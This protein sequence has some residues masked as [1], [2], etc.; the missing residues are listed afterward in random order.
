MSSRD[1]NDYNVRYRIWERQ[2]QQQQQQHQHQHQPQQRQQ[3]SL[4]GLVNP[5]SFSSTPNLNAGAKPIASFIERQQQRHEDQMQL[6]DWLKS[7]PPPSA[8][9]SNNNYFTEANASQQWNGTFEPLPKEQYDRK[10]D[11]VSRK[12]SSS[13]SS[14][15]SPPA[16]SQQHLNQAKQQQ[17]PKQLPRASS[18]SNSSRRNVTNKRHSNKPVKNMLHAFTGE[19][20]SELSVDAGEA[21]RVLGEA[22]ANGWVLVEKIDQSSADGKRTG[23]NGSRSK[24]AYKGYIPITY[25]SS[26]VVESETPAPK[27]SRA[28]KP[29]SQKEPVQRQQQK[30]EVTGGV[31]QQ[32]SIANVDID[33]NAS[34]QSMLRNDS[35]I[36]E[37]QE[38]QR[39]EVKPG[40][41]VDDFVE[42]DVSPLDAAPRPLP[43]VKRRIAR[44]RNQPAVAKETH[45]QQ[46]PER[47]SYPEQQQQQQQQRRAT[48]SV[49]HNNQQ[50]PRGGENEAPTPSWSSPNKANNARERNGMRQ[51]QRPN[52]N[53]KL[54]SASSEVLSSSSPRKDSIKGTSRAE[55]KR[56]SDQRKG[57]RKP[58][59]PPP[60]PPELPSWDWEDKPIAKTNET[61]KSTDGSSWLSQPHPTASAPV[62]GD[63]HGGSDDLVKGDGAGGVSDA[64]PM[65]GSLSVP[66]QYV[67]EYGMNAM[68]RELHHARQMR[69]KPSD[70]S[71]DASSASGED[72]SSWKSLSSSP[73]PPKDATT[74]NGRKSESPR[75]AMDG[76]DRNSKKIVSSISAPPP[77]KISATKPLEARQQ[78]QSARSPSQQQQKKPQG[79]K[80]RPGGRG[81][82]STDRSSNSLNLRPRSADT[83][84]DAVR[85]L[86]LHS[87][88]VPAASEDRKN[89][90]SMASLDWLDP[91]NVFIPSTSVSNAA[92]AAAVASAAAMAP[93]PSVDGRK[94]RR[95][96]APTPASGAVPLNV[97]N[98]RRN[99]GDG[100]DH[101]PDEH[102]SRGSVASLGGKGSKKD[103]D[104][105]RD[106]TRVNFDKRT[107]RMKNA[108]HFK[109]SIAKYRGD[110]AHLFFPTS[111]HTE[112]EQFEEDDEDGDDWGAGKRNGAVKVFVRKRPLFEYEAAQNMYDV[113]SV[114]TRPVQRLM[115]AQ[116]QDQT[117]ENAVLLGAIA[118]SNQPRQP[119]KLLIHNCMMHPDMRR[120][121]HK[122][123]WFP[124]DRAFDEKTS[125][126][127]VYTT[128]AAPL[129][130]HAAQGGVG[131][132]FMYG[133]T[134]SGKT[135]TMSG[136]EEA[137]AAHLFDLLGG[138]P[139]STDDT[140]SHRKS[141]QVRLRYF[142]LV[143][144]RCVDLIG[145]NA[146]VELKLMNDGNDA[147]RPNGA[148]EPEVASA[149][150]L[151]QLL[152][153]GKKRRATAATD[154]NGGSS[155]SHAV[156]QLIIDH[157]SANG[158]LTLV[159]C[160]GSERKE[161]S[162]YHD[163]ERQRESTE[164]NASLYVSCRPIMTN[165]ALIP[166][167]LST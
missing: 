134:G 113:V 81:A 72:N 10:K 30:R 141:A 128:C 84:S 22:T 5:S 154:I 43:K 75:E 39:N 15:S 33:T 149:V 46:K 156:C 78:V 45:E 74:T 87:E 102:K 93:A 142:E 9:V 63:A 125:N 66:Y 97:K 89:S 28:A 42:V 108:R 21:V 83:G 76:N 25:L 152:K 73:P 41:W 19:H 32:S 127:T 129:V 64:A 140:N 86:R 120:M 133:Q 118:P 106:S 116:Q 16:R 144:K 98:G 100:A 37:R 29:Q 18:R 126:S 44:S 14:S 68:L 24:S 54:R 110:H 131:T 8:R 70:A 137:M 95:K 23:Q 96:P 138:T 31:T 36:S 40:G 123:C 143:G 122:A 20:K 119:G 167:N 117:A 148:S 88:K 50:R 94:R 165:S 69:R 79:L 80:E 3:R 7:P 67:N 53:E 166:F 99:A 145:A 147:V 2:Q 48:S 90:K 35:D 91:H 155:R 12:S 130:A 17:E 135:H 82:R 114:V 13:S 158:L 124:S 57:E 104:S 157:G 56:S 109:A 159:D 51:L 60:P 55:A 105:T 1:I 162:M 62:A 58:P 26:D 92:A 112:M 61:N 65:A 34:F 163:K 11:I 150:H 160:A 132:L 164:I 6:P 27:P 103:D 85:S 161:D 49:S 115:I 77:L 153:L 121:Y 111:S 47:I 151:S 107:A 101:F 139:S 4:A 136:I 59:P 71:A 146:G 38:R 52:N